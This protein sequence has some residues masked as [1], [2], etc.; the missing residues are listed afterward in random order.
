MPPAVAGPRV[1]GGS[2]RVRSAP[3]YGDGR[4]VAL[5]QPCI[6]EIRKALR[7]RAGG[8]PFVGA[9]D[10]AAV[11]G[12]SVQHWSRAAS[13][14]TVP[15]LDLRSDPGGKASWAFP[16]EEFCR[17]LESRSNMNRRRRPLREVSG[18]R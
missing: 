4:P 3:L 18:G 13:R 15:A 16:V 5:G 7:A 12:R 14:G 6:D 8:R 10:L 2:T 9:R 1:D 11:V 17:W